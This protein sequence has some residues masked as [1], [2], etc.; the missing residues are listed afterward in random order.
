MTAQLY[1]KLVFVGGRLDTALRIGIVGIRLMFKGSSSE[2]RSMTVDA[3][4]LSAV[5]MEEK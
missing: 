1:S 5:E 2:K 4:N 3:K